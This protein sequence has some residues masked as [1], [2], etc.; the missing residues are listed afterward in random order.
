MLR[1]NCGGEATRGATCLECPR[2]NATGAE[3]LLVTEYGADRARV[4][5]LGMRAR[6]M[7]QHPKRPFA[8]P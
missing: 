6:P 8:L 1:D 4:R 5:R 2:S 3:A 7:P